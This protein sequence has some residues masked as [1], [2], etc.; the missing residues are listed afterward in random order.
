MIQPPP[1]WRFGRGRSSLNPVLSV[2]ARGY[3]FGDSLTDFTYQADPARWGFPLARSHP[4]LV[5]NAGVAND[6]LQNMLDRQA[7]VISR[8]QALGASFVI[9]RAG[10]NGAGGG[11]FATKYAALVDA[12]IAGGVFVI[13][14]QVPPKSGSDMSA[15]NTIVAA[16]CAARP[17]R[18]V[19]LADADVIATTGYQPISGTTVDGIH[20]SPVGAHAMGVSQASLLAPYL[21]GDARCREQNA[22]AQQWCVNPLMAGTSGSKSGGTGTVP[23]NWA[24]S[25][26]GAGTAFVASIVAA[27]AQ[28]DV[29][30]P[31]LRIELTQCGGANHSWE[32]R[33]DLVHPSIAADYAAV[34]TV[35]SVAE[36]RLVTLDTA[37]LKSLQFGP[38]SARTYIQPAPAAQLTG[39]GTLS[40][41]L[42]M[43]SAYERNGPNSYSANALKLMLNVVASGSFASSAGFIDIRCASAVGALS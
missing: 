39:N 16:V 21:A 11:D 1:S 17:G 34:R 33:G 36:V 42:V 8:G 41:T 3:N 6:T 32:V 38:D 35:D 26:V 37:S 24:V 12:F 18:A 7:A 2:F 19:Y 10:T 22:A 14:C 31:W 9:M 5:F 25:A 30:V 23:S 40:H 13:C 15:L 28:D 43:R 20:M 29:Q 4:K 27:D